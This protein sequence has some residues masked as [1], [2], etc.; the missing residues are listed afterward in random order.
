MTANKGK[1][2]SALRRSTAR[3]AAV[4]AL[5]QS[6]LTGH[7]ADRVLEDFLQY[8]IGS[9]VTLGQDADEDSAGGE[10]EHILAPPDGALLAVIFRGATARR[11]VLDEM[12]AGALTGD[13]TVE[14]LESVLR[15]I[16]RGGAFELIDC[17]DVPVRVVISEYVDIAHA[18]YSGPEPGLVN[19]V[20]DRIARVVRADEIG[21]DAR[22]R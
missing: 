1:N 3:L 22:P 17:P 15:A 9:S 18:F 4:Q 2:K 13:W 7:P 21:G 12:I 5:Y 11:E 14:R 19:A 16:L 6:E 8:G 20:L 10:V